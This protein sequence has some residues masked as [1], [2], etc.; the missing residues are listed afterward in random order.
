MGVP[1]WRLG[2][3][4]SCIIGYKGF[5]RKGSAV[6]QNVI[7]PMPQSPQHSIPYPDEITD[8]DSWI[9]YWQSHGQLWRT[10][11]EI[12]KQRQIY[13]EQR[14][15][16]VPDIQA[17]IYPFKDIQLTRAD[18]EWLLATHENGRGPIDW[19][20]ES[21]RER[22]GL[23]LRGANLHGISLRG[24]P[25]AR[26]QAG[27]SYDGHEI[28]PE[29]VEIA[30]VNMERADLRD[31]HLEGANLCNS[32][33]RKAI[34]F[35]TILQHARMNGTYLEEA[36]LYHAKLE[37]VDAADAILKGTY[38]Y[39]AHFGGAS[40]QNAFFDAATTF[41]KVVL[42]DEKGRFASFADAHWGDANI[43]VID[44]SS[45]KMLGDEYEARQLE[46]SSDPTKRWERLEAFRTAV[47]ANR[48]LSV[49]LRAQ[50]LNED[51]MRFAYRAQKLQRTV[52][53]LKGQYGHYFF[54]WFL[55]LLAGYGYRPIRS[56]IA[57]LCVILGFALMYFLIG[58]ITQQHITFTPVEA[59]VFSMT[60]FHGRGFSPGANIGL[61]NPLTILAALEA[62]VGLCIE[63]IFIATVTQ[64]LFGK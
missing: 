48:Q 60:S 35:K 59:V 45:V 41:D 26:L 8:R 13:L 47:Q 64:R 55:D 33:M 29:Q 37:G 31:T 6:N 56:F 23:D 50:G 54:S 32:N 3:E 39:R 28:T 57:Y 4:F 36:A 62:F 63:L 7:P 20:D 12:D 51:A 15:T 14:R 22:E 10:E 38:L 52:H 18:I 43:S 11:P 34:M 40:L 1:T 44:W 5:V 19:N 2:R 53:W 46:P 9:A 16:I 58:P 42:Q 17:G 27:L 49:V 30:S 24:L 25:L 61:S 21:Q